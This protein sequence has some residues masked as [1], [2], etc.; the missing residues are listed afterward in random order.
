MMVT[1]LRASPRHGGARPYHEYSLTETAAG[2]SHRGRR[3]SS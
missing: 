3:H 1:R 2:A